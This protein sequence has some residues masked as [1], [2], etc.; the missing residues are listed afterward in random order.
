MY[1]IHVDFASFFPN[2][3]ICRDVKRPG[4]KIV[5]YFPLKNTKRLSK[6]PN[7]FV[8]GFT[9]FVQAETASAMDS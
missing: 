6:Q 4:L 5:F 7:S 3:K 1:D 9:Y 2:G 8:G